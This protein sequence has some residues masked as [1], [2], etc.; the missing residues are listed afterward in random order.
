MIQECGCRVQ[1][2]AYKENPQR[3]LFPKES[4]A[5]AMKVG[6]RL[7]VCNNPPADLLH[8]ECTLRPVIPHHHN[9]PSTHNKESGA[10]PGENGPKWLKMSENGRQFKCATSSMHK[11]RKKNLLWNNKPAKR[12]KTRVQVVI[13][14]Q[15]FALCAHCVHSI[16]SLTL[17]HPASSEKTCDTKPSV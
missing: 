1:V 15:K 17:Q 11:K 9:P 7:G 5:M 6:I 12:A 2:L 8:C 10:K 13:G 14:I 4:K 16:P 3:T